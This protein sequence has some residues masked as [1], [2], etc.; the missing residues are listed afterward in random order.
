MEDVVLYCLCFLHWLEMWMVLNISWFYSPCRIHFSIGNSTKTHCGF[1]PFK[2]T[3]VCWMS[4]QRV[5][6]TERSW[7]VLKNKN[8]ASFLCCA[9]SDVE[10]HK[11]NRCQTYANACCQKSFNHSS[12]VSGSTPSLLQTC[13]WMGAFVCV[14]SSSWVRYP[15]KENKSTLIRFGA[16][17]L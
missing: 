1:H 9:G 6:A 10:Q 7:D 11:Q 17:F 4:K 8:I 13:P 5:C 15:S 14:Q 16:V 2:N 12:T 3:D